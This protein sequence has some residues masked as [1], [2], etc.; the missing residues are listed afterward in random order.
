MLLEKGEKPNS[1][2]SLV[3]DDLDAPIVFD[4]VGQVNQDTD[5]NSGQDIPDPVR[6]VA[7]T[8]ENSIKKSVLIP[9]LIDLKRRGREGN[10][11]SKYEVGQYKPAAD[12]FK[13]P[14]QVE[15]PVDQKPRISYAS[16]DEKSNVLEDLTMKFGMKKLVRK[17]ENLR[18][19]D[20]GSRRFWE[21]RD[22]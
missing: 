1:K 8:I 10:L 5:D 9:Q 2:S 19:E 13:D 18:A 7:A 17:R 22:V 20:R 21:W 3:V 12:R 14:K 16:V 11:G 4:N 6:F 15:K